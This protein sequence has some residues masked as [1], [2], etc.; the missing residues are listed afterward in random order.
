[1]LSVCLYCVYHSLVWECH[2]CPLT[3]QYPVDGIE[4][5]KH[6]TELSTDQ[7]INCLAS[8]SRPDKEVWDKAIKYCQ[9]SAVEL[10]YTS[11]ALARVHK[12]ARVRFYAL[13]RLLASSLGK[14][15]LVYNPF[16]L[17]IH[18]IPNL[19]TV[20]VNT[21]CKDSGTCLLDT[22][23]CNTSAISCCVVF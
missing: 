7:S 18:A 22:G 12:N 15:L 4:F 16:L 21:A 23:Y 9:N 2:Y 1:M 19:V 10:T 14:H 5:L 11:I 8:S 3:G 20:D 17:L 13:L 6:F